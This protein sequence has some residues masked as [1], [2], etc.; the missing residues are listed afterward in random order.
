MFQRARFALP[1]CFIFVVMISSVGL[2]AQS[3]TIT[4]DGAKK[5][6]LID[7]YGVNINTGAWN[8][9]EV[10][11]ALDLLV[12]QLGATV[13]RAVI[14]ESDW[15]AVNDNADPNSFDWT[16]FN[17]VYTNAKFQGVWSTLSYLNQ[18]GIRSG[19]IIS[20]MGK[21]PDWMGSNETVTAS[22][23]DEYV[24]TMASLL[25][26]ARNTAG[27]QFSLVSPFNEPD[28]AGTEGPVLDTPQMVRILHKLAVKLDAIG[29]SDIRFV[30][31]EAAYLSDATATLSA[32]AVDPVI[33]AKMAHWGVHAYNTT[34]TSAFPGLIR[35]SG[36]PS[37]SYWIT[38]TASFPV[39]LNQITNG[40][41]ANLVW[42]GFDSVYN[43]A[44]R[45]GR[46][47]TP[48]NDSVGVEL[49]LIAYD[50]ST[51]LYTPR[52][53]FYEHAQLFKYVAPGALRIGSSSGS[54]NLVQY[55]FVNPNGQLVVVGR[56]NG[57]TAMTVSGALTNVATPDFFEFYQTN[58]SVSLK[59]GNDVVV[60]NGTFSVAIPAG[61]SFTLAG[62]N[63]TSTSLPVV[64]LSASPSTVASGGSSTLVWTSTGADS[65]VASGGWSGVLTTNGTQT[66][67][68][69][70]SSA[71]YTITCTG[72]NGS[73]SQSV[74]VVVNAAQPAPTATI[75][76]SPASVAAGASTTL[77]WNS[78][79][80]SNC[81]ASGAW[82]GAV[83]LSG[84][85]VLSSLQTSG[86]YTLTC[87]GNGTIS[88]STVVTVSP[89][90]GSTSI[91]TTQ[92][93][94]IPNITDNTSYELGVKFR[95][96]QA[97]TITAIRYYKAASESTVTHTGRL[98]SSAG[99]QLASAVFTGE[100]ASGWQVA[101]L[102]SP[103]GVAAN[104]TYVVSVNVGSYYAA[105]NNALASS[106]T[107]GPL[108]TVADGA[109]GVFGVAGA[110][111]K[112][113]WSNSNYF[114]DVV[115]SPG[116]A[117]PTYSVTPS[118]SN[119]SI[120]P[121]VS[122]N[123]AAGAVSSF[124]V[125]ANAGF[126]LA[127]VV[128]GTCPVGAWSGA[129]YTTGAVMAS[130]AVGFSAAPQTFTVTP[131]GANVS[132]SP[133][134]IQTVT[135]GSKSMFSVV[136]IAGYVLSNGV[137][138]NCPGGA[139]SGSVYTTGAIAGNCSVSFSATIA[140]P[141]TYSVTPSSANVTVSP[142]G[143]QTVN[144]GT[145]AA[146]T[147]LPNQGFTVS[148][149]VGGSCQAGGW[150]GTAYTTGVISANCTVSFSGTLIG[151]TTYSVFTTQLPVIASI[152]DGAPYELGMKFK[153][154][155]AGTVTAIRYY[156][157]SSESAGGHIGRI[158]S[159][160]GVLLASVTFAAE[161]SSG[162][163]SAN[164]TSPL[165]IAAGATY[166]V[167]VNTKAYYAATNNGLQSSVA[168]GPLASVA[169]GTNG[170]F[171][172]SGKFPT[173]SWS[174]SNYFRDVVYVPV[175]Q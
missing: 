118:G 110:F 142:S 90:T 37:V 44:I 89:P 13:F 156:K 97:G 41:T 73:A 71:T 53:Q 92:T 166:T 158:W 67:G 108:S 136:P 121:S 57:S 148:T 86:T 7:G 175:V 4:V 58:S 140:P 78:A 9:G 38:E 133:S 5:F 84:V 6:Q 155:Q 161:T 146:F 139:W 131:S 98:W 85:Q 70:A 112:S 33:M 103:L 45:D 21:A 75:S 101:T 116:S 28:T 14:E 69:L 102:A 81:V 168:N 43:H 143:V 29:L 153:S 49:P 79:N 138:G 114:R 124:V 60:A 159:S 12:D 99:A 32:I 18:K 59:R 163:Q 150:S 77:T 51:H 151:N 117:Q 122:Q 35:N 54:G 137:G 46:G 62:N 170:V 22:N 17:S 157:P 30:A 171:G 165:S 65:C 3:T 11:P 40:P 174:F 169:D 66:L 160:T 126:V 107:N 39:M 82:S 80:A 113:S 95:S 119:V 145:K 162:W 63:S 31:P 10:R 72:V 23:E 100:S 123:V 167:S 135:Y 26:Y 52:K 25:Y 105:T 129:T 24:E 96:S 154:N 19:L 172:S 115:F 132:L 173:Q 15:E 147:V 120:S 104:T 88:V 1:V 50:T 83:A 48:P 134:G 149:A 55:S 68:S 130:C 64:S 127:S 27:I 125:T 47:S 34:D 128:T 93:P 20:L 164:L 144:S 74:L 111:P 94:V 56:N 42:D 2:R 87:T 76:A 152:T 8:S 141:V 106:I 109:N 36:Y 61:T 16:Y 91:F